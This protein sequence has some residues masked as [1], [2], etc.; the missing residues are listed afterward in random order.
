MPATAAISAQPLVTRR[1]PTPELGPAMRAISPR[2]QAAVE[3]LFLSNGRQAEALRLAG[4]QGKPE[5]MDVMASRLFGDERV[6]AAIREECRKRIDITEPELI[7]T[8][9]SILRDENA[10]DAD[11]LKAA[12]LF[13]DRSNP[14]ESK[15]KIDV[16]HH[17][18]DAERDIQHY[19]ALKNIGA[20]QEAFLARFG[21]HGIARVEA[22]ILAEESK[23]REIEGS[24][25][26]DADY[27]EITVEEPA[28]PVPEIFDEEFLEELL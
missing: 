14:V 12:A 11:R 2:W 8:V 23:R 5:S 22:M 16:Q 3:A 15:L 21:P 10:K 26:I 6:R 18:T 13:W 9:R 28:E 24:N 19:R 4:Y 17:V 7:T 27:Q 1:G 20:P 25:T